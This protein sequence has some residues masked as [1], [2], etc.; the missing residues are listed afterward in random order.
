MTDHPF[1]P[2]D[3]IA[4]YGRDSHGG[5]QE[6]S[7]PQQRA[8]FE[9]WCS[10]NDLTLAQWYADSRSGRSTAGRV[11]FNRLTNDLHNGLNVAGVVFWDLSRLARDYDDGSYFLADIRRR[12][13]KIYSLK[14]N[15]P[16]G[17][18][19]KVVESLKLW[20]GQEYS[21][22]LSRDIKRGHAYIAEN[23][24]AYPK[25]SIPVGYRSKRVS[26]G[27]HKDGSDRLVSQLEPD[28]KTAGLVRQAFELRAAGHTINEIHRRVNLYQGAY[29]SSYRKLLSNSI[30]IGRLEFGDVRIDDF[31]EPLIERATWEAVRQHDRL[32]PKREI[33]AYLLSGLLRCETCG[34]TMVGNNA[35]K[36]RYYTCNKHNPVGQRCPARM[37]RCEDLELRVVRTVRAWLSGDGPARL[38]DRIV[39][40]LSSAPKAPTKLERL[41]DDYRSIEQSA[42]NIVRA[43]E[44]GGMNEYLL[45]RLRELSDLRQAKQLE[46]DRERAVQRQASVGLSSERIDAARRGLEGEDIRERQLALRLFVR[47]CTQNTVT[48]A[49]GGG[50]EETIPLI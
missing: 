28:P 17:S 10:E 43:I 1:K 33:S 16:P 36:R 35:G 32:H 8:V 39:L 7:V 46:I 20:A 12:G 19:G 34:R 15:I 9:A 41:Q 48:L 14:D 21:E 27:K 24:H 47:R 2:G 31:C 3:R 45:G 42:A 18:I 30:Y 26:I 4:A 49:L 22:K 40:G 11:E 37:Q 50:A 29:T 5:G 13:Y 38:L 25:G 44:A 6:L 23:Y